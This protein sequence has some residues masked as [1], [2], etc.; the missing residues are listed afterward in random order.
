[1]IL[2]HKA[3]KL[4][5]RYEKNFRDCEDS[6]DSLAASIRK[7]REANDSERKE[8]LLIDQEAYYRESAIYTQIIHDLKYLIDE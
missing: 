6:I 2:E 1:M 7:A 8:Y 4:L 3:K 5:D